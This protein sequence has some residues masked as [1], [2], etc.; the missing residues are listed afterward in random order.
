MHEITGKCKA[1]TIDNRLRKQS[2][3]GIMKTIC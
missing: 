2:N 1:E 3:Y